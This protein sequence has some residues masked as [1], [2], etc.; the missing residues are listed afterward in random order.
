MCDVSDGCPVRN[1]QISRTDQPFEGVME[2]RTIPNLSHV[3]SSRSV[4]PAMFTGLHTR[5]VNANDRTPVLKKGTN[6]G[7]LENADIIEPEVRKAE[8]E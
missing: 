5:V 4:L 1:S 8:S 3:Y 6:L 2:S 7:K